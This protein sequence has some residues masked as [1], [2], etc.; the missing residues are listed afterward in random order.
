MATY[1]KINDAIENMV[2]AGMSLD[3]DTLIMAFSNTAP[4]SEA[5]NPT[6]DGNG[7]LGNVTQIAYTNWTDSLTT[8][9]QLTGVTS[10][11]T[12]GTYKLDAADWTITA[13]GG[14]VATFRYIYLANDT[15]VSPVDPLLS[16]WDHGSA[17]SL[18]DGDSANINFNASGIMQIA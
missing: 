18:A 12:S 5:S 17:I 11:Q 2:N 3:S 15:I 9:R 10:A 16:A 13:S 6:G 8:D 4:S 1:T 14:S 7:V